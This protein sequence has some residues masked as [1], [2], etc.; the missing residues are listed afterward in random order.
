MRK[1]GLTD[2]REKRIDIGQVYDEVDVMRQGKEAVEMKV[3]GQTL[4]EMMGE[5]R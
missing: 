4:K 5:R 3:E 2:G 1:L